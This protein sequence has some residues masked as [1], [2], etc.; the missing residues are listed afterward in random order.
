MPSTAPAPRA[1]MFLSAPQSSTPTTSGFVYTRN[2]R[3]PTISWKCRAVAASTDATTVGAGS[4]A[5]ISRLMFGP[6]STATRPGA[7]ASAQ[8]W[9]IRR[10]SSA[11]PFVADS[12]RCSARSGRSRSRSAR[13]PWL[14]AATMRSSHARPRFSSAVT[15]TWSGMRMPARYFRFSRR[16]PMSAACAGSRAHSTT[17]RPPSRAR[18]VARVVP[19]APAPRTAT[20]IANL[21]A[22]GVARASGLPASRRPAASSSRGSQWWEADRQASGQPKGQGP[23]G[24]KPAR[25]RTPAAG[26]SLPRSRGADARLDAP[27]DPLDVRAMADE[28]ER[29][30]DDDEGERRP[31]EREPSCR[32]EEE[33]PGERAD[34]RGERADRH[35]SRHRDGD[36]E[37]RDRA[38]PCRGRDEQERAESGRHTPAAAALEGDRPAMA[39]D[40]AD[41]GDGFGDRASPAAFGEDKLREDD[42]ERTLED[43]E[44][45]DEQAGA[46]AQRSERVRRAG[47]SGPDR[48][49]VDVAIDL[50]D[51]IAARDRADRVSEERDEHKRGDGGHSRAPRSSIL[52]GVPANPNRSRI[53]F[54]RYRE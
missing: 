52:S 46:G 5:A 28:D 49:E 48:A 8:S 40:C 7:S 33:V 11:S 2:I 54:S 25:D 36:R 26:R 37:E 30:C 3:V 42:R 16:A 1:M 45:R 31:V 20:V 14:G 18:I 41:R 50:A 19:H 38:R 23:L 22:A 10:P 29:A 13:M 9:L 21:P 12:R 6:E 53:W 17:S 34:D 15:S 43:V 44:E 32:A 47:R 27:D 51:E 4:P 39:R 35:H 24:A